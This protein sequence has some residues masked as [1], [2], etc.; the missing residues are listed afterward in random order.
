L[1]LYNDVPAGEKRALFRKALNSGHLLRVI[2][3]PTP[4]IAMMIEELGFDGVYCSGA[5]TSI[6]LG[7][8]D[9]GLTTLSEVAE[10]SHRIARM[11]GLPTI[12][13]ADTGFGETLNA[14]R[15]I[16]ELENMGL[17]GCHIEDQV[18]PKRCGHLDNKVLVSREDFAQKIR[19]ATDA[20]HD[21]NFV[22]IARTDA[23]TVEG[24]DGAIDRAKAAVN[25]GADMIFPEA[26]ADEG[27]FAAMRAAVDVPLLANITEFGKSELL[28]T[29]QLSSLGYNVALYPA[30]AQRL[31]LKAVE[32]GLVELRDKG[33]QA[34][35][36]DSMMPRA[37][38]YELVK[39]AEYGDFDASI[40]NFKL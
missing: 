33:T 18:N 32:D 10:Q 16:Q 29:D 39:Y 30:T 6:D 4:L 2:G 11:V 24:L 7:L 14:A 23:R 9:I 21:P 15:T 3:A 38:L 17:A 36:V 35:K 13:D 20:R 1:V 8:P 34:G 37:R 19:A 22:V 27:E 25:A 40:Y 12:I 28:T 31:A 26:M 5:A